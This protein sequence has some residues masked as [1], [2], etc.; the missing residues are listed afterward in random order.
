MPEGAT[1]V[2]ITLLVPFPTIK[3]PAVK[4]LVPVPPFATGNIPETA[5]PMDNLP[6]LGATPMPPDI[7]TFP[8]PTSL[9]FPI[10]VVEVAY[11]KSPVV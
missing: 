4:E 9:S 3:F 10:V 6:Q 5:L 1:F 2:V 7:S 8:T 11:N